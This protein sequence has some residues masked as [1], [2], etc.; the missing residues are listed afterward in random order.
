[1]AR[2]PR[3]L[4]PVSVLFLGNSYTYCN[5]LNRMLEA[6]AGTRRDVPA[7]RTWRI[8]PGGWSLKWHWENTGARDLLRPGGP[9][10]D[11][12]VLQDNS[13]GPIEDPEGF[14]KYGRLLCDRVR[15]VGARPVLFVT[16]ARQT[17][18][19]MQATVTE[20]YTALAR[21]GGAF[22]APV[23]EA[24]RRAL[25]RRPQLVLHTADHSHPNPAGSYLAACVFFGALLR[26]NPAG[27]PPRV[28][29]SEDGQQRVLA[30]LKRPDAAFLQAVAWQTVGAFRAL[31]PPKPAAERGPVEAGRHVM[32]IRPHLRDIRRVRWPAGFSIRPMRRA[33]GPLWVDIHRDCDPFTHAADDLFEQQFGDAPTEIPRRCFLIVD[34]RGVAVGTI[35]AWFNRDFRGRDHGRIHWLAVRKAYQGLGLAKAA[36]SFALR[37]LARR[38]SRAYLTTETARL[39]AIRIYL[40]FGFR[41]DLKPRGARTAWRIV[42]KALPHRGLASV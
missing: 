26:A 16:W 41:P 37:R 5:E 42:K 17:M 13:M 22:V 29:I 33:E 8:T 20:A 21:A 23:G 19:A 12:V 14:T 7:V 3:N 38:H 9:R 10:L 11:Y 25:R 31:L 34:A 28:A 15:R 40:D 2:E 30:R 6:F 24:W 27:L 39:A 35:S 36:V 32:M 1:M 4:E 18:P